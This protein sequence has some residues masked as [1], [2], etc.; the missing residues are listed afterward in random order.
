[1][2]RKRGRRVR[3]RGLSQLQYRLGNE[4]KEGV[5][6]SRGGGSAEFARKVA[7]GHL[8]RK[9]SARGLFVTEEM[10]SER[11]KRGGQWGGT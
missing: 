11:K 7:M 4:K 6:S 10:T 2:A 8:K 5:T 1:V 9:R 3:R